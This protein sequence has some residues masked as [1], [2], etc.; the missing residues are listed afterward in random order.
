MNCATGPSD[1]SLRQ[2]RAIGCSCQ[3][4]GSDTDGRGFSAGQSGTAVFLVSVAF[5]VYVFLWSAMGVGTSF[6]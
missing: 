3:T 1:S 4:G 6:D 2:I 5:V